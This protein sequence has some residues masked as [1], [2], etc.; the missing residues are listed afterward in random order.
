MKLCY[1]V[2]LLLFSSH[3]VAANLRVALPDEDYP[4]FH[5]VSSEN[6]GIL[7]DVIT[8]FSKASGI[9]VDYVFVPEMRSA[10][11]VQNGDVDVR[12]ESEVW[13]NGNEPYYWS[14]EIMQ[15]EDVMVAARGVQLID[16]K[17]LNRLK[18]GV[19]LGRFGYVYPTFEPLVQNNILHRENF[20]S[21]LE[22]LQSLYK[23]THSSPRFTVISKTV[24]NWYI[25]HY[26]DFAALVVSDI[27]VGVAPLQ[28]QF[29][30]NSKGKKYAQQFNDFLQKLKDN[31]ELDKIIARY[32]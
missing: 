21:D 28:L 10:K 5:F 18:S 26:P 1:I 8:A 27:N 22:V 14:Q 32:Q 20:Y 3:L 17:Q 24:L 30:Y 11:M 16:L 4:P 6:K 12:M 19:L 25:Q 9:Q 15:V 2:F 13:L 31:G 29:A 7:R 23:D